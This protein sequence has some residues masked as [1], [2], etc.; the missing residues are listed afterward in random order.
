MGL[1]TVNKKT[2]GI[3][4]AVLVLIII[5]IVSINILTKPDGKTTESRY[6]ILQDLPGRY[7]WNII[8]EIELEEYIICGISSDYSDGI[9]FF[10]PVGNGKYKFSKEYH[11]RKG[12]GMSDYLTVNGTEY[13]FLWINNP[14]FAYAEIVFIDEEGKPTNSEKIKVTANKNFV[15]YTEFSS[16]QGDYAITFYN[17]EGYEIKK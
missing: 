16:Q 15:V 11:I 3:I 17:S 5:G 2:I 13:L 6:K 1:I 8:S 9:A 14:E 4:L 10:E 7:N 12:N